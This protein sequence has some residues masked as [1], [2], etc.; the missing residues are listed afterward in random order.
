MHFY[1]NLLVDRFFQLYGKRDYI[2]K[3]NI[4]PDKQISITCSLPKCY[5]VS[6]DDEDF[7]LAYDAL[8]KS[9]N[10][11]MDGYQEKYDLFE[12]QFLTNLDGFMEVRLDMKKKEEH[13]ENPNSKTCQQIFAA[14][15]KMKL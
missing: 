14:T 12:P 5:S 7:I 2:Y 3:I 11:M 1:K 9:I 10:I 4:I 13:K 15:G 6:C 8:C